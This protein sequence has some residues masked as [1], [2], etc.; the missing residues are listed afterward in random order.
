MSKL[1]KS[2]KSAKISIGENNDNGND[3]PNVLQDLEDCAQALKIG[4][5]VVM[6]SMYTDNST[7]V[8]WVSLT[9][10]YKIKRSLDPQCG[11][12]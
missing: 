2:S 8:L 4:E 11:A 9:N 6:P 1:N 12:V 10:Y 5:I 7:H 3:S